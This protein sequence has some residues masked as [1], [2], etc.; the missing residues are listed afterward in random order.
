M[1]SI[2]PVPEAV[3]A[4]SAGRLQAEGV[5]AL[6]AD[7][8]ARDPVTAEGIRANDPQRVLRALD[9]L[10]ATGMGIA[11]WQERG[12]LPPLLPLAETMPL[13]LEVERPT[14]HA[15]IE[16]RIDR[17]VEEG[18]LEEVRAL[19]DRDLDP[20]LPA[21]KAIGVKAFAAHLRGEISLADAVAQTKTETRRYAKRQS[22][23]LRN[24]MSDWLRRP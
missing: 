19:A 13:V 4:R 10:E 21:M 18:A 1:P 6:H 2:P 23:W 24:Q 22:T 17:M 16:A 11:A 8:A 15:R 7:L 3:R 5:A 12:R 14:L 20:Q 9:V